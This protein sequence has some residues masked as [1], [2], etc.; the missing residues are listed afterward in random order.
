MYHPTKFKSCRSSR[1]GDMEQTRK[2]KMAAW[3]PSWISNWQIDIMLRIYM[4]PCIILWSLKAAGPLVPEIWNIQ[5]NPRWL[6]NG[7]LG[8]QIGERTWPCTSTCYHESSHQVWRLYVHSFQ[9]YGIEKKIQDGCLVAILD[10]KSAKKRDIAHLH[11]IIHHPTK[12]EGCRTIRS[13]N[14]EQTILNGLSP[15]NGP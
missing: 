5:E 4:L 2:S 10:F 12:F 7:H 3:W 13:R 8:F 1:S 6:P 11:V 14:V 15:E 9:R